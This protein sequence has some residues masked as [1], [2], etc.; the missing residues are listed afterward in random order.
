ME[1]KIY[2]LVIFNVLFFYC[3]NK[4]IVF[5]FCNGRCNLFSWL[6]IVANNKTVFLILQV[7]EVSH[8]TIISVTSQ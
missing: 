6:V 3:V 7:E 4:R 1:E 5:S 2:I 8:A